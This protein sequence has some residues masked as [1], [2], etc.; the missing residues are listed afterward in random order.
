[1]TNSSR[2][3]CDVIKQWKILKE[4]VHTAFSISYKYYS[5]LLALEISMY[6]SKYYID[7]DML[8]VTCA[9]SVNTSY[10]AHHFSRNN[11]LYRKIR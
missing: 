5:E 2:N 10:V 6:Q 4:S 7:Y 8:S 1:M 11:R 9:T 3:N